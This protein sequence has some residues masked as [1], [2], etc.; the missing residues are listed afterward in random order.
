[1]K[2]TRQLKLKK[3]YTPEQEKDDYPDRDWDNGLAKVTL[4]II[5][6]IAIFQLFIK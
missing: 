2:A 6:P 3:G 4:W 5:L 1:M